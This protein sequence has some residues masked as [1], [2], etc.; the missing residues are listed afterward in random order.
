M[1]A[2]RRRI[3]SRASLRRDAGRANETATPTAA[4]S[5]VSIARSPA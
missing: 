2:A 3:D 4:P 1:T 5:T